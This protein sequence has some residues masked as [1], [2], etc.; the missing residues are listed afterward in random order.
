[1]Q[2][3]PEQQVGHVNALPNELVAVEPVEESSSSE[4]EVDSEKESSEEEPSDEESS[5]E[6]ELDVA[7]PPS[8][9]RRISKVKA[10]NQIHFLKH[11][12]Y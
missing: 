6:E 1:M 5:S 11:K 3:G 8:K 2:S 4:S 9:K 10:S 7:G 12:F